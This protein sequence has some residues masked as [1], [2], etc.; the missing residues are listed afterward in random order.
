[1]D[2]HNKDPAGEIMNETLG[3]DYLGLPTQSPH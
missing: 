1:M 2:M 3:D